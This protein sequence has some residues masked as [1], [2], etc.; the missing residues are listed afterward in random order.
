MKIDNM[1]GEFFFKALVRATTYNEPGWRL[2]ARYYRSLQDAKAD[3]INN[4]CEV[5]W[6]VEEMDGNTIYAPSK[7]ELGEETNVIPN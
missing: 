4:S 6:P 1:E 5:V 7:M 3:E 2:T